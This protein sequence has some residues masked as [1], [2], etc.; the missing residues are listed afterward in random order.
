MM[1]TENSR[2]TYLLKINS[3]LVIISMYHV[4]K[5]VVGEIGPLCAIS[6]FSVSDAYPIRIREKSL[7]QRVIWSTILTF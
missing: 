5:L 4:T 6:Q 3:R 2:L 1:S 7:V